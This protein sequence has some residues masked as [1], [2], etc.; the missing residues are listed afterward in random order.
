MM[1]PT[2]AFKSRQVATVTDAADYDDRY[3]LVCSGRC[4]IYGLGPDVRVDIMEV[5][6]E[7]GR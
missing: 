6:E 2:Q 5:R 3:F 1:T 4:V 7:G